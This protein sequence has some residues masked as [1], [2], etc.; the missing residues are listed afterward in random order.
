MGVAG[1]GELLGGGAELEGEGGLGDELGGVGAEDVGADEAVALGVHDEL[2][3][4]ALFADAAGAG[5][6]FEGELGGGIADAALL[7]FFFGEADGGDF[8]VGVGDVGDGEVVDGGAVAG[9]ELGYGNAFFG[10]F[11]GEHGAVDEVSNGEDVGLL[12][13][14]GGINGDESSGVFFDADGF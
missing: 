7:G 1:V 9:E 13:L 14:E 10:G 11:V 5:V 3:E 8:G 6:G 4:A 2:D 12:G